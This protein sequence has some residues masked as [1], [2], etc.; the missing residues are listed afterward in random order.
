[1]GTSNEVRRSTWIFVGQYLRPTVVRQLSEPKRSYDTSKKILQ[2]NLSMSFSRNDRWSGNGF[3]IFSFY[4]WFVK[5][6]KETRCECFT[7]QLTDSVYFYAEE[8]VSSIV[9]KRCRQICLPR[10]QRVFN[11]CLNI[12]AVAWG[13]KSTLKTSYTWLSI[14]SC[15]ISHQIVLVSR[16][17]AWIAVVG[18]NQLAFVGSIFHDFL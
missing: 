1:M 14:L 8:E 12:N 18:G 7:I 6:R 15:W 9:E 5:E 10:F 2:A 3:Q 13:E 16:L 17:S 11:L 4:F